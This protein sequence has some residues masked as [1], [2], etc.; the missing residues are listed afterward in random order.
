MET[1]KKNNDI[2][3][4][5]KMELDFF[6]EL[7]KLINEC[8]YEKEHNL[9]V[10]I[11]NKIRLLHP[12]W[13]IFAVPNGGKRNSFEVL[14]LQAEG[15]LNGVSDLII[16]GEFPTAYFVE[17]KGKTTKWEESQKKFK[18][19]LERLGWKYLLLRKE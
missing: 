1:F 19:D 13:L 7:Q 12:T 5:T 6:I 4:I 8:E 17:M 2:N 11:V 15:Q 16:L 9:Q 18:A 3:K 14:K 10:L